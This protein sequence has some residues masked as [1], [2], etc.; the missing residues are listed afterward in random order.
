MLLGS[1]LMLR[2]VLSSDWCQENAQR[3]PRRLV[4]LLWI[5]PVLAGWCVLEG[6][7]RSQVVY[8]VVLVLT[9]CGSL[10]LAGTGSTAASPTVRR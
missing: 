8:G 6:L 2:S 7:L 9:L 1:S 4:D 5:V 3:I 10:A